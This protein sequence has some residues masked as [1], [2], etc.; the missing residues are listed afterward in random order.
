MQSVHILYF[1][2]KPILKV[3]I[4]LIKAK[5]SKKGYK[6]YLILYLSLDEKKS[7][8]KREIMHKVLEIV[9]VSFFCNHLM[10]NINNNMK[11]KREY[12]PGEYIHDD[13]L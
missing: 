10:T 2:G 1:N 3:D 13:E 7:R 9:Q 12:K 11:L 8:I 6:M 4:S 5:R